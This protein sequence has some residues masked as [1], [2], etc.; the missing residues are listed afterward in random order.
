MF[1]NASFLDI[2]LLGVIPKD[3]FVF[4]LN[5]TPKAFD[6]SGFYSKVQI[7][8]RSKKQL[9]EIEKKTLIGLMLNA[10]L[11]AVMAKTES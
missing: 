1:E 6:V 8:D 7:F 9:E 11:W 10:S 2:N 5:S 4:G 3:E